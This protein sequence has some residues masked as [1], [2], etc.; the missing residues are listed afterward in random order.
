MGQFYY[1]ENRTIES[2]EA[3]LKTSTLLEKLNDNASLASVYNRI[4]RINM[5][6]WNNEISIEYAEKGLESI[7]AE[8]LYPFRFIYSFGFIR[9]KRCCL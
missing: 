6:G 5:N 3:F 4:G 7:K 8:N 9:N 1:N 2:L